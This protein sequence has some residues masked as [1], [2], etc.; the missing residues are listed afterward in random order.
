MATFRRVHLAKAGVWE[1][2]H[3]GRQKFTVEDFRDAVAAWQDPSVGLSEATLRRG[4]D[5]PRFDGDPALGRVTNLRVEG[6]SLYG[7]FEDLDDEFASKVHAKYPQRSIEGVRGVTIGGKRYGLIVT[8]VALLGQTPPAMFG[9]ARLPEPIATAEPEL[10]AASAAEMGLPWVPA[11]TSEDETASSVTVTANAEPEAPEGGPV[12]DPVV[13]QMRARLG[14]PEDA[15][16][17]DVAK[18][19]FDKLRKELGEPKAEGEGEQESKKTE[20]PAAESAQPPAATPEQSPPPPKP[21]P[22]TVSVPSVPEGFRLVE[23]NTI[24]ALEEKAEMGVAAAKR[25]Q[26]DDEDRFIGRIAASGKL[27]PT[28]HPGRQ[29]QEANFRRE[30]QRNPGE[31]EALA[32]HS[33]VIVP[34]AASGHEGGADDAPDVSPWNAAELA[35]FPELKEVR[36]A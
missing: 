5:D 18:A 27:L 36:G 33:P 19:V 29:H 16:E 32:E 8:G 25:Q 35:A 2:A 7:D 12:P 22:Q 23:E 1:L 34:V 28:N 17:E 6:D 3:G 26:R 15:T 20:P 9:L 14:L 30:W 4:H 11:E 21:E 13:E 10:I 31:A 24:K